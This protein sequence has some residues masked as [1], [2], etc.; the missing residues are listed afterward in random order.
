MRQRIKK[1]FDGVVA[2][3]QMK[4]QTEALL[5]QRIRKKSKRQLVVG[6]A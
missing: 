3:E 2:D 1:G 6:I 5:I 4:Q